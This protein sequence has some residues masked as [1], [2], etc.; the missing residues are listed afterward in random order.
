MDVIIPD[1][2]LP[3]WTRRPAARPEEV[4]DAALDLFARKGFAATRMDDI[5]KAAGLSKAA[6]YLYF[7]SKEDV[8][9]ALVETRVVVLR[10]AMAE[11]VEGMKDDPISGLRHVI[12]LWSVSS[13][14]SQ[15]AAIPRIILAESARFPDLADFYHRV[16]ISRT[17]KVLIELIEAGIK[18]G[19]FRAIDPI[20]AARALVSPLLFEMLR[21]QA[22]PNEGMQ[23]PLV[24]VSETFFDLFLNGIIA[25]R[26]F[27]DKGAVL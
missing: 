25:P 1:Q 14:D 15:L 17:Q 24:E 21:R 10:D 18:K 11:A 12:R 23:P 3:R 9:K 27:D 22:F 19:L 20:S 6:I 13:S 2:T 8:F 7:P 26:A 4:L 16:V 5:A